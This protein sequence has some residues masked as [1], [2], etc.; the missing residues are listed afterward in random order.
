MNQLTS[1]LEYISQLIKNA[2][3]TISTKIDDEPEDFHLIPVRDDGYS[4]N[5]YSDYQTSSSV[6]A[7]LNEI[8]VNGLLRL[9]KHTMW[10]LELAIVE[11]E[12]VTKVFRSSFLLDKRWNLLQIHDL[13][14]SIVLL[15]NEIKHTMAILC[16]IEEENNFH[17]EFSAHKP[18]II[19]QLHK[20]LNR[21]I[22]ADSRISLPAHLSLRSHARSRLRTIFDPP[23][24][25]NYLINVYV[26][27][28]NFCVDLNMLETVKSVNSSATTSATSFLKSSGIFDSMSRTS[29]RS[30]M[31]DQLSPVVFQDS[32]DKFDTHGKNSGAKKAKHDK[33]NSIS[34]CTYEIGD[35]FCHPY[36]K[37]NKHRVVKTIQLYT[38]LPWL[39][40]CQNNLKLAKN[41]LLYY[42]QKL[43]TGESF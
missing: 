3:T 7:V 37:N 32:E 28:G 11:N 31:A 20:L 19:S 13:Q 12:P 18:I 30:S 33:T 36:D 24:P 2:E 39:V 26:L 9:S 14:L 21:I 5:I 27:N 17:D 8:R 25:P 38:N 6:S 40:L 42:V 23:L 10:D 29:S 16:K 1:C 22:Q 4:S 41:E 34:K 35:E 43:E 15:V